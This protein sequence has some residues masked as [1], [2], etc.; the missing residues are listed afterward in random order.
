LFIL[1]FLTK[2]FICTLSSQGCLVEEH[3]SQGATSTDG[4][5]NATHKNG[6]TT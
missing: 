4:A 3:Y 2:H 1:F 6:A 5:T